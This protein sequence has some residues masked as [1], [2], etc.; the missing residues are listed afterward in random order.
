MKRKAVLVALMLI[1]CAPLLQA[2]STHVPI[3][4]LSERISFSAMYPANSK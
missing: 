3:S 2:Q 4:G 1:G